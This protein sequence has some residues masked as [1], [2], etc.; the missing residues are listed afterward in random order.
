MKRTGRF[1]TGMA[2][3]FGLALLMLA[4][5]S[6]AQGQVEPTSEAGVQ[7]T[8]KLQDGDY[9]G[10]RTLL[11]AG[12]TQGD[13]AACALI[14][15]MYTQATGV[16]RDLDRAL[17]L[18]DQGCKAGT[19]VSCNS[20]TRL[21][22]IMAATGQQGGS[23][24]AKEETP[25]EE[26][27]YYQGECAKNDGLSCIMVAYAYQDGKG[28]P[29]DAAQALAAFQKACDIGGKDGVLG[30]YYVGRAFEEGEGRP[31]DVEKAAA[32]YEMACKGG[33][34]LGCDGAKSIKDALAAGGVGQTGPEAE[35]DVPVVSVQATQEGCSR[36]IAEDCLVLGHMYRLGKG[37]VQDDRS[38]LNAYRKACDI[39]T[40]APQDGSYACHY[41]AAAYETGEGAPRDLE[42]ALRLYEKSCRSG[43]DD[44]CQQARVVRLSLGQK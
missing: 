24:S 2:A 22:E 12:C 23:T 37:L 20:A 18:F 6:R 34:D 43:E 33:E 29:Q 19:Q 9:A 26:F 38:A 42:M 44:S 15:S 30:C 36:L 8:I 25:E 31:Q 11:D 27:K 17:T 4:P 40:G 1:R 14:A 16:E 21:R 10:A 3:A 13:G 39:A 28:A 32:F 41:L 7:G 5:E 35:S